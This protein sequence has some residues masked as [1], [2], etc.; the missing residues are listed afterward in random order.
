MK[1]SQARTRYLGRREK[2]RTHI[3]VFIWLW[4]GMPGHL[5][6][7]ELALQGQARSREQEKTGK[8]G[9]VEVREDHGGMS[10]SEKIS[11]V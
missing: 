2:S 10:G 5:L 11:G 9:R 3:T 7:F 6:P 1:M 8:P 4:E